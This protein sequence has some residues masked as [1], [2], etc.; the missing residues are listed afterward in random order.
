MQSLSR[1]ELLEAYRATKVLRAKETK[2]H[3]CSKGGTRTQGPRRQS[4]SMGGPGDKA[5]ALLPSF[6][7]PSESESEPEFS[8]VLDSNTARNDLSVPSTV[9]R[10]PK[11]EQSGPEEVVSNETGGSND[12]DVGPREVW[13]PTALQTELHEDLADVTVPY[14]PESASS[15]SEECTVAII[16]PNPKGREA[17]VG[18]GALVCRQG[19]SSTGV[20]KENEPLPSNDEHISQKARVKSIRSVRVKFEVPSK[21]TASGKKGLG[22]QRRA[23]PAGSKG[24]NTDEEEDADALSSFVDRL[25]ST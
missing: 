21:S 17:F 14:Q 5:S 25:A 20:D 4:K 23:T 7:P 9:A 3:R 24:F 22:I 16:R 19:E 6:P 15:V 10:S 18:K 1:R 2:D 11:A 8:C 13:S 12:V